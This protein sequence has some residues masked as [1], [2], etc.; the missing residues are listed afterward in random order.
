M[1]ISRGDRFSQR[2][3]II[4]NGS[5]STRISSRKVYERICPGDSRRRKHS[6]RQ[7]ACDALSGT[8]SSLARSGRRGHVCFGSARRIANPP[9]GRGS[10]SAPCDC[11]SGQSEDAQQ[12]IEIAQAQ[13]TG[14]VTIDGYHFGA[15]YQKW[16]KAA[17]LRLLVLDDNGHADHYYADVVL[18]Q[19]IH[20]SDALYPNREPYTQLLLGTRYA[21]LR[22]EFW[23]WRDW[24]REIPDVARKVLVTMGGS[25]PDNVTLKILHALE[26]VELN[27]LE[28][29]VVVGGN[30][31]HYDALQA[32]AQRSQHAVR[33]EHNVT[34]MPALMAWADVAVSAGGSTC[35]ELAFLGLP[36]VVVVLA[37]NQRAIVHGLATVHYAVYLGMSNIYYNGTC[38][39]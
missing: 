1:V 34:D 24:Q 9:G 13:D 21:L 5:R 22:R 37:D 2:L 10:A 38:C 7:R 8:S 15:E 14:Y 35:W 11:Y 27:G 36:S 12:V 39:R 29:T 17:G 33:L 18:N 23:R 19:N 32:A 31:P 20:A 16:L 28:V 30:N 6:D 26:Q 4:P 3:K 25:D